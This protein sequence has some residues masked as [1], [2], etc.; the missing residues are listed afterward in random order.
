MTARIL[1]TSCCS[2]L[3]LPS[4][5]LSLSVSLSLSLSLPPLSF[6][7]FSDFCSDV[8][9]TC[10]H[11]IKLICCC[12][13]FCTCCSSICFR[14]NIRYCSIGVFS[15]ETDS[16]TGRLSGRPPNNQGDGM[17]SCRQMYQ[18]RTRDHPIGMLQFRQYRCSE[19]DPHLQDQRNHKTTSAVAMLPITSERK[20]LSVYRTHHIAGHV[21]CSTFRSDCSGLQGF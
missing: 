18:E 2:L 17:R 1:R 14:L 9:V 16:C 3:T 19:E 11:D 20:A 7:L 5:S 6:S 13:Q 12:F 21:G 15:H 4:L 8:T 10:R